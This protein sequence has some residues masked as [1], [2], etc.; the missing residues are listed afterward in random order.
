MFRLWAVI[1]LLVIGSVSPAVGQAAPPSWGIYSVTDTRAHLLWAMYPTTV[2]PIASVTKLMTAWVTLHASVP[3]TQMVTIVPEDTRNGSTTILHAKDRVSVR[4]LLYLMI[5]SSDNVAARALARTVSGSRERFVQEMN[6]A[7]VDLGMTQT[8]YG[9][10]AGLLPTNVSTA[11]DMTQLML[12]LSITPLAITDL[13]HTPSYTATVHRRGKARR[14]TV[15]NTNKL[16]DD[17]VQMSKTGF[18]RAAG[19]CLIEWVTTD[20]NHY[21]LVVLGA[22]TKEYRTAIMHVLSAWVAQV[23]VQTAPPSGL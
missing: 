23:A 3:V 17:S 5:V 21:I 11:H 13:L 7:A 15:R 2:R 14:L 22:P 4:D 20:T 19:Y 10:P 9:D 18:T 1:G 6:R 8:T 12:A 16:L